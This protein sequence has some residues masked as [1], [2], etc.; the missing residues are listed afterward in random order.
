MFVGASGS[1]SVFQSLIAPAFTLFG[2]VVGVSA[3][4]WISKIAF[5]KSHLKSQLDEFYTPL[6]ATCEQIKAKQRVLK[7]VIET[8]IAIREEDVS[9]GA[10]QQDKAVIFQNA[11]TRSSSMDA[12]NRDFP[13]REMLPLLQRMLDRFTDRM[14]LA[15]PLTFKHYGALVEHVE[16]WNRYTNQ[17]L[18]PEVIVKLDDTDRLMDAFCKDLKQDFD[19][20]IKKAK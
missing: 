2:V 20:L 16:K 18:T 9:H 4:I 12:Y 6:W 13:R 17:S 7:E 19:R 14:W 1:S 11:I 5:D 10:N 8:S 3:N 15:E